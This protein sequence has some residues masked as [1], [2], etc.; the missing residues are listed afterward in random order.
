[1]L[2]RRLAAACAAVVLLAA[3]LP[4]GAA[5]AQAPAQAPGKDVKGRSFAK[6][7]L[8]N[9]DF[10]GQDL[11]RADF[12]F[13]NLR[14][15]SFAGADLRG[16]ILRDCF[17]YEADFTGADLRG[18]DLLGGKF[19]DAK[20]TR[21]NLEGQELHL[22]GADVHFTMSEEARRNWT[23]REAFKPDLKNG[24]LTF[25]AANLRN[26]RILGDLDG[27]DF[28]RA[29]LRGADLSK[30]ANLNNA[31]FRGASYDSGT[32]WAVDAAQAGAVKGEELGPSPKWFVGLWGIEKERPGEPPAKT[33]GK[34]KILE[35]GTYEWDTGDQ[36]VMTGSW[37]AVQGAAGATPQI[38]LQKGELGL[39]WTAQ[40]NKD[41]LILKSGDGKRT[42]TGF[43]G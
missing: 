12:T 6:Q 35:N 31:I 27:V 37:Q 23:V 19:G 26:A 9:E 38:T 7:D 25:Q 10:R 1:M 28:R 4:P 13:A 20:M 29:D 36:K 11:R 15:A 40:P 18:A 32:K 21:A 33:V 22:A 30:A 17:C 5:F 43:R 8:K 3:G 39:D 14:N 34:L 42:R 16:A 41:D 24:R 2:R